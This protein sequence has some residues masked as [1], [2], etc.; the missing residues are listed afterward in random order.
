MRSMNRNI[1]FIRAVGDEEDLVLVVVLVVRGPTTPLPA[2]NLARIEHKF[3]G[4]GI[5]AT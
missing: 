1:T 3:E 4:V 5:F 2:P